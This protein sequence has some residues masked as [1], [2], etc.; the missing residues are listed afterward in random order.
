MWGAGPWSLEK[1]YTRPYIWGASPEQVR[2]AKEGQVAAFLWNTEGGR[3]LDLYAYHPSRQK[4]IRITNLSS[5]QDTLTAGAAEREEIRKQY[6]EP[7]AGVPSYHLSNDGGKVTFSYRGDIWVAATDASPPLRLTHTKA[8]ETAPRLSPDG[9]KVAYQRD[10]QIYVHDLSTGQLRQATDIENGLSLGSHRWSPDSRR[11]LYTTESGG[12]R[13]LLPNYSGRLVT[14]DPFRRTLAGDELLETRVWVV[15]A[16]GGKPLEMDAGPFGARIYDEAPEWSPD[17][18]RILRRV[19]HSSFKKAAVLVL[20]AE[21]GRALAVNEQHDSKWVELPF[22]AWSPDGSHVLYTSERDGWSHLYVVS[23]AG[24]EPKQITRGKWEIHTERSFSR[25]PEWVGGHIYYASTEN[26]PAERQFYRLRPDGTGKAK[27]SSREGL[28]IGTVSPGEKHIA[29]MIADLENP[30]DLFVDGNRVTTSPR[31]E[32][33]DYPW[34]ETRFVSFPSPHD[35]KIVAAKLLLPPGYDPGRNDGRKWPAVF[36]IHGAGYATSVLKQWGSYVDLRFVY[37]SHLANSGYVIMD[38]D[39]RGSSGY[40]RDWR[41]DVY[42]HLGGPDLQDVLGA[43]EYLRGLGNIDMERLGIWGISYGGFMTNMAMFLSP[44]T[45]AAG[46]SF[47]SVNDW[48]NY[49]AGYTEERLTKPSQNPEAYRRSSPIYFS[50]MLKNPLLI[51][52][53]MV[54]NNVLFQDAVQLTEKLIQERKRFDQIYY[55]QESHAF[56]RDETWI[57]ALRRTTDFFDRH[58]EAPPVSQ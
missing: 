10:G 43:V 24:G 49:N 42:L 14:A 1:L 29:M 35:R 46:A 47:A 40:G 52:H 2:W 21:F 8:A 7:A 11:F 20:D 9:A 56:V 28:N 44:D 18:S 50:S 38:L 6:L 32:F 22:A 23:S 53:G 55:P 57:D 12:R 41:T 26:G 27:L 4:L 34:P 31:P 5:V 13:L 36:F 17:S 33:R 48:Q 25:D 45:F 3:F 51:V 39:Y 54:D 15:S 58:L 30:F 37:N 19:V 16:E